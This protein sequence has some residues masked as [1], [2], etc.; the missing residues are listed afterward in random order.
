L[1]D[2]SK[3]KANGTWAEGYLLQGTDRADRIWELGQALKETNRRLGF[4]VEGSIQKRTGRLRKT[5]A[6]AKVRNVAITNCPVNTDSRLDI[7]AKSLDAVSRVEDDQWEKAMTAGDVGSSPRV[8]A[9]T[10]TTGE[11]AARIVSK[12]S[13]DHKGRRVEYLDEEEEKP[14]KKKSMKKSLSDIEAMEWVLRRHPNMTLDQAARFV[15]ATKSLKAQGR[16]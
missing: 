14:S 5:V 12:Q 8:P 10:P 2:G 16:L 6:K 4:S 13:L 3:A 9:D 7:L 15:T 1:P 11:G